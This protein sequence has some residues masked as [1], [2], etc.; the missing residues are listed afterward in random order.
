MCVK[1]LKYWD[2]LLN[3]YASLGKY[4]GVAAHE[5][6]AVK[7]S[8]QRFEFGTFLPREKLLYCMACGYTALVS[9]SH[10]YLPLIAKLARDKSDRN[11]RVYATVTWR[12]LTPP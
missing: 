12:R 8:N 5:G 2:K 4:M 9:G 10:F 3:P 6:P 11:R 1:P 7:F